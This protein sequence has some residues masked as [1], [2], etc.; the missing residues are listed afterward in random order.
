MIQNQ[1]NP[2]VHHYGV[3]S[4][5]S[6]QYDKMAVPQKCGIINHLKTFSVSVKDEILTFKIHTK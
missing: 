1:M 6:V 3:S 2:K 5:V 4:C